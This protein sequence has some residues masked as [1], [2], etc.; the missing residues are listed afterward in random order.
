MIE[1]TPAKA[2]IISLQ[3]GTPRPE[4]HGNKEVLTAIFKQPSD[5]MHKLSF[6]GLDG[7]EQGDKVHHGGPDKAVCVYLERWYPYWKQQ[8]ERTLEYGAFGENITVSEWSEDDVC[9]GDKLQLGTAL[10]QVSQPRQPCFK[11]G[12]RNGLP[13][14][15]E[16]VIKQGNTG[17]YLRVLKEGEVRAGDEL[18]LLERHPSRKSVA[19][20]NRLMYKDMNDQAGLE[21][22]LAVKELAESWRGQL[23]KRLA[24]MRGADQGGQAD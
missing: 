24:K 12:I 16:L 9:I 8:L 5:R 11:L 3:V 14:L 7:D 1:E 4:A 22:L 21:A 23:G 10:V 15:P 17:F 2:S 6:T 19:E 20:A 13:A 18:T